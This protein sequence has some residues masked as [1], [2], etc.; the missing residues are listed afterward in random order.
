[1]KRIYRS[2]TQRVIGGICGGLGEYFDIDPVIIR[3]IWFI[4][5]LGGVGLIAYLIAW[6]V[7][8]VEPEEGYVIEE[9]KTGRER[10]R[11]SGN[12]RIFWGTVLIV[13]GAVFFIR[14]IWYFGNIIEQIVRFIWR[15]FF[16][17]FLIA[18][19]IYIIVNTK[20]NSSGKA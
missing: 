14:E 8:P 20:K 5:L 16:P 11:S 12:P 9:N 2:R 4:L 15:Y 7:I 13:I 1:M 17:A 10:K 6:I 18:L 3:V 19:G